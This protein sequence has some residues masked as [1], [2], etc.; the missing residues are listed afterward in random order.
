MN[1][2]LYHKVIESVIDQAGCYEFTTMVAPKFD[3]V[4]KMWIVNYFGIRERE[5]E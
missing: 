2:F 1:Y 4:K 5:F 3:P